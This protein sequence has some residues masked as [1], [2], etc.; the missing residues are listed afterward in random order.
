MKRKHYDEYRYVDIDR[1][2]ENGFTIFRAYRLELFASTTLAAMRVE[3][4]RSVHRLHTRER[5]PGSCLPFI[6]SLPYVNHAIIK[7]QYSRTTWCSLLLPSPFMLSVRHAFLATRPCTSHTRARARVELIPGIGGRQKYAVHV[8]HFIRLSKP[9]RVPLAMAR[10][11][12][13]VT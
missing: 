11:G 12:L 10:S 4:L 2:W 13:F 8:W 7:L 9:P 5:S 3:T 1:K 6:C